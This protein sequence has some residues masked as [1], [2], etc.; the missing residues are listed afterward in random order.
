M[1]AC[2]HCN[3]PLG[4]WAV[5]SAAPLATKPC[6]ACG[7]AY[8]G[9]GLPVAMALLCLSAYISVLLFALSGPSP[10]VWLALLFG[11]GLAGWSLIRAEPKARQYRWAE[12][13]KIL[14]APILL[15][16]AV[17]ATTAVTSSY[18]KWVLQ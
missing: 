13:A 5:W 2:P 3:A 15:W 10:A 4:K 9:G 16:L 7:E 17:Q 6:S 8:F 12:V 1:Y 11:V 14:A 18:A